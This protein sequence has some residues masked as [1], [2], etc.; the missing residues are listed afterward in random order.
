M[1][2]RSGNL[3]SSVVSVE[4]DPERTGVEDHQARADVS[5]TESSKNV[6]I[7]GVA[8]LSQQE[9]GILQV[10]RTELSRSLEKATSELTQRFKGRI[11][12]LE[13]KVEIQEK[14]TFRQI[15]NERHYDR[16]QRYLNFI[17]ETRSAICEK[18]WEGAVN[19]LD[20]FSEAVKSF[21]KD[22]VTTDKYETG[23]TLVDRFRGNVSEEDA[24]LRKLNKKILEV[25]L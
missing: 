17:L 14:P 2:T 23:W 13:K 4:N 18:D 3:L 20:A 22:V 9:Q 15:A 5:L 16:S 19:V 7:P 24:E 25:S 6:E 10:F 11:S 12:Y 1:L 21:Q 8:N